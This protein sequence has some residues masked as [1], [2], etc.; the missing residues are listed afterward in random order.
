MKGYTSEHKVQG[1]LKLRSGLYQSI[2]HP[3]QRFLIKVFQFN[4]LKIPTL[5]NLYLNTHLS[6]K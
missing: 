5:F 3:H 1:S 2:Y 6:P 4:M